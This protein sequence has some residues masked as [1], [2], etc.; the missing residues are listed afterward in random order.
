MLFKN[1]EVMQV[2]KRGD[3]V[4]IHYHGTLE[5]GSVFCS[6]YEKM[7]LEFTIGNGEIIFENQIIEMKVGETKHI[8]LPPEEAFGYYKEE[9]IFQMSRSEIPEHIDVDLQLGDVFTLKSS[10]GKDIYVKVI[11]MDAE[12]LTLDA[13]HPLAGKNLNFEI[14]LLKISPAPK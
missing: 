13:N 14:E 7:P 11:D 1:G 8:F 9:G 10:Q 3:T 5:D 12:T 6:T 4:K 2:A